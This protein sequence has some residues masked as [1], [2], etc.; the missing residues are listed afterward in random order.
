VR[1]VE[2]NKEVL[3]RLVKTQE[4]KF[5]DLEKMREERNAAEAKA[6]KEKLKQEQ[7]E[8][9]LLDLKYKEEKQKWIG[10]MEE[11]ND[12]DKMISNKDYNLEE[13]FL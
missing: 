1:E 6:R 12:D 10:A 2:K 13:D 7:K 5:P 9:E 11:Y 4:E 8:K 3:K